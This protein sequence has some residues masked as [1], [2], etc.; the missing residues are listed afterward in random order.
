MY[1][2]LPNTPC[3][4]LH[5]CKT[6]KSNTIFPSASLGQTAL[7]PSELPFPEPCAVAEPHFKPGI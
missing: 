2:S 3:V 1:K 7:H 4:T 5:P 6:E